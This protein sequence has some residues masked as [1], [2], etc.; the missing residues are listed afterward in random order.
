MF[1]GIGCYWIKTKS[2]LVK[3]LEVQEEVIVMV[4]DY[5]KTDD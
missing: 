5:R 1:T 4:I 2:I 3:V